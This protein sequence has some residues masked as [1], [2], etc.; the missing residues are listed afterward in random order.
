MA[1]PQNKFYMTVEE[2]LE[3]EKTSNIRH[4]Y[5]D[6]AVY[7]M[8]DESKRHNRIGG[9]ILAVL[10]RYLD[11]SNFNVYFEKVKLRGVNTFYYP[12]VV[13]VCEAD[14]EDEYVFESLQEYVIVAQDR[15][16]IQ[17][18]RRGANDNWAV[19]NFLD[20]EGEITFASVSLK[21][22]VADVYRNVRFPAP[23]SEVEL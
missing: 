14:D 8:G 18:H 23:E 16:W 3:F 2:Y 21:M 12:D 6:G 13:V 5:V 15:I 4:E 20:L 7:A 1:V 9:Q 19:E 11:E 10:L 22:K 17:I